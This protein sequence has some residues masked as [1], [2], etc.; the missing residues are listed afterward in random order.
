MQRDEDDI[1][2]SALHYIK[3]VIDTHSQTNRHKHT[4]THTH[5]HTDR[6]TRTHT[7]KHTPILKQ[8]DQHTHKLTQTHTTQ[9]GTHTPCSIVKRFIP[10]S[11]NN[12]MTPSWVGGTFLS[13]DTR[14]ECFVKK[15][16]ISDSLQVF[17]NIFRP[18]EFLL[19]FFR[20][21]PRKQK[22]LRRILTPPKI[23]AEILTPLQF[24]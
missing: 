3:S 17:P 2:P 8:R 18:L 6:H 14:S 11:Y 12:F 5:K 21:P 16:K 20:P 24:S 19:K 15:W 9:T 1:P 4:Q 23:I 10:R 22:N 7:D 13:L